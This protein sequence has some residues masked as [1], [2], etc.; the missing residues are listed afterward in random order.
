MRSSNKKELQELSN[1]RQDAVNDSRVNKE[2][3]QIKN[4]RG[5]GN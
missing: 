4:S 1:R 3:N 2:F 5:W